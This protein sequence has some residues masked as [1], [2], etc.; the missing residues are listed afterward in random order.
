[1][2]KIR[3]SVLLV[4]ATLL[5]GCGGLA[6][7]TGSGNVVTQEEAITGFDRLDVSHGFQVAVRQGGTFSVIIRVNDDL[8]ED[9]TVVKQGST[10]KIGLK[11]GLSYNLENAT[12]EADV[13][14]PE[15]TGADLAGGSHLVGDVEI[16]D[17]VFNLS[18]GSHVTLSGSAGDLTVAANGGSH[19]KLADLLV[20]NASVDA[21]GGS[22]ATVNPSGTLDAVVKGGS[23]VRYL[24]SP[25][26]GTIDTD[27]S[28]SF[29]QE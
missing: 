3:I 28:S 13:T 1:M 16:G 12:L 11:P 19:A 8:V 20:V 7:L 9:L 15:L 10:L 5:A 2:F 25:T 23:H 18:G 4:I 17:V 26:L 21:R 6:S 29:K 24:G 22:H 14:M 27:G